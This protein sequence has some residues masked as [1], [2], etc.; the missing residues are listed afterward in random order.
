MPTKLPPHRSSHAAI[1]V[2]ASFS[3]L[4][5]RRRLLALLLI[6]L[7]VFPAALLPSRANA[8]RKAFQPAPISGPPEPFVVTQAETR[9][10]ASVLP[11]AIET[12]SNLFT[13]PNLPAGFES[14]KLPTR[15]EQL[16]SHLR[17]ALAL[18]TSSK[19]AIPD[20]KSEIAM[21]PPSGTVL[22]DFDGDGKADIG[23]WQAGN[24]KFEV[25]NSGTG[26]PTTHTIGSSSAVASPGDFDGDGK[27][28]AAVF[29]AG[30]WTIKK[31]S[32]GTTQNISFGT[33][34][35]KP[36]A[37]DYDGDG[38]TD[39]AVFRPST[40]AWWVLRS[41]DANATSTTFGSSGDIPMT[42][43]WDGDGY[44]DIAIFRPSNGN[45]YVQRSTAGSMQLAWGLSTDVPVPADFDGDNK[46]D[47][48]VYRPS[49][50]A[51]W[52][53]KSSTGF[54]GT[55][56]SYGWG[57]YG[58]QPVPADYDEDGEA[59]FAVWRPKTGVWYISKSSEDN[60]EYEYYALG[61]TGDSAVPAAY[62]KQV[63]TTVYGDD[64][65]AARLS[66][67][68]ARAERI[69]THET[70][71]GARSLSDFRAAQVWMPGSASGTTR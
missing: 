21:P 65:A 3:S 11:N 57:N 41:S 40:N 17:P 32:N 68:N 45:W 66:P 5:P 46:T 34:G 36:V 8:S 29:S 47:L 1:S 39:A 22:F 33:S 16:V 26:S 69:S 2:R 30:S 31:S 53:M 14:A 10:V 51:W 56:F 48:A 61:V 37:A 35:D 7:L 12:L 52:V 50:G 20:R 55:H 4:F 44:A 28:D 15:T 49:T 67:K 54:D 59:D 60:E 23:R 38:K 27:T 42:G 13:R 9:A 43:N 6:G 63:A 18:I 19:S 71:H 24:T 58:D 62:L 70:F 25:R 64:M